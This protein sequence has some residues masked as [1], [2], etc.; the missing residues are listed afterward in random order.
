MSSPCGVY[1]SSCARRGSCVS[2]GVRTRLVMQETS[3]LRV[4]SSGLGFE[5]AAVSCCRA[6]TRH[7][8]LIVKQPNKLP[9]CRSAARPDGASALA[10]RSAHSEFMITSEQVMGRPCRKESAQLCCDGT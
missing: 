3:R 9:S 5:R 7:T 6:C 8:V 4:R 2:L 1:G 10:R